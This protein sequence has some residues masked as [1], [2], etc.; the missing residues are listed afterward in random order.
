MEEMVKVCIKEKFT[1]VKKYQTFSCSCGCWAE[2]SRIHPE[3]SLAGTTKD[4]PRLFH[5]D[6]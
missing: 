5:R 4:H 2:A 3:I 1:N 6:V